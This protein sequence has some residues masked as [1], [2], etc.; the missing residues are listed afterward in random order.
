MWFVQLT[1][2]QFFAALVVRQHKLPVFAFRGEQKH[3]N[4][5]SKVKQ[6]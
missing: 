2:N 1:L 6:M 3:F 5:V 4:L